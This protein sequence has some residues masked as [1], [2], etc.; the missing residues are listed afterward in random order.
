MEDNLHL[1]L[2]VNKKNTSKNMM[3]DI[4]S[5]INE[6]KIN[7][8]ISNDSF[9]DTL[10]SFVANYIKLIKFLDILK[11]DI[12]N[13]NKIEHVIDD[14][15]QKSEENITMSLELNKKKIEIK[16]KCEQKNNSKNFKIMMKN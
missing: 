2:L 4:Y 12:S 5:L 13:R 16:K 3:K 7:I 1:D 10:N 8:D 6:H 14:I 11:D 9:D 15:I